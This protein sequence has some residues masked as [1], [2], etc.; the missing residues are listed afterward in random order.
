MLH[1]GSGH[2][3]SAQKPELFENCLAWLAENHIRP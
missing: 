2:M 3:E 1:P